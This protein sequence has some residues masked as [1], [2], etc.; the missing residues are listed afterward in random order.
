MTKEK[1]KENRR[2]EEAN[3]TRAL[4]LPCGV[5]P[6]EQRRLELTW[7]KEIKDISE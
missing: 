7:K 1:E 6:R 3:M 4:Y 2:L 5:C